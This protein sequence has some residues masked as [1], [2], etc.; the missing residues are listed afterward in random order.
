MAKI[1]KFIN[2]LID[3]VA[4]VIKN[5]FLMMNEDRILLILFLYFFLMDMMVKISS[6]MKIFNVRAFLFNFA[7]YAL[8]VALSY[9][10]KTYKRRRRFLITIV[11]INFILTIGNCVYYRYYESFLSIS[12]VKQLS[13]FA[14][15]PDSGDIGLELVTINDVVT[16]LI[17]IL[18]L[19]G[20]I[21][22]TKSN[23]QIYEDKPLHV[24][25]FNRGNFLR[26]SGISLLT[27]IFFMQG[28]Q[29]S[30][31][32]KLWNRPIVVEN[33]GLATYHLVDSVKSASL[34]VEAEVSEEEYDAFIDYFKDRRQTSNQYTNIFDGKN[35]IVIHGESIEN[36]VI[37]ARLNGT[38][39]TPNLNKLIH[40][41]YYFENMYSQQSVGTSSDTEFTFSSS[42]L[43]VNNGTIFLTHFD[44][45]YTTTQKLL[46]DKGYFT[47][48]MHGNYGSFWNRNIMH[49]QLGYQEFLDRKYYEPY[50]EEETI[51][52]GI[53]DKVFFEKSM[54]RL[55]ELDQEEAPYYATLLMLTNHTP[56]ADSEK[57]IVVDEFGNESRL[58]CGS[59]LEKTQICRY[60]QAVHYADYAIGELVN[61]LEENDM[62]DDTVIVL[63]GDHPANLKV[64]D[65]ELFYKETTGAS[66]DLN[67]LAYNAQQEVPFLIWSKDIV[68]P[69]TFEQTIGMLDAAP[70]LQNM[71]GIYN[72]FNLGKDYNYAKDLAPKD[73]SKLDPYAQHIVPFVDGDWSDGVIYY[74]SFQNDYV[75]L[76]HKVNT[77]LIT[78]EYIAIQSRRAE[79]VIAMS[80]LINKYDLLHEYY[81]REVE[82]TLEGLVEDTNE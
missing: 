17:F 76:D 2:N 41:G 40:S 5:S 8:V 23:N 70:I 39:I 12:I 47:V 3:R 48:S 16:V 14:A 63:Y 11:T 79:E 66:V 24:K 30:Q 29:F 49:P 74:D 62:L 61:N 72:P 59:N 27:G 69:Q 9:T 37:N 31:V 54:E 81:V 80:N 13:L 65:M 33:F 38:E 19:I 20:M 44:R 36:F 42:L 56:W 64:Q 75:L 77:N 55:K 35:V 22:Y 28:A 58:S 4:L 18:T 43:P 82:P 1:H 78:S 53:S 68:E 57:Y 25:K 45:S 46:I 51:G 6:G 15:M 60:L 73:Y 52:L 26:L 50:T 67:A 34:F 21:R 32:S 10:F 71:L 7:W